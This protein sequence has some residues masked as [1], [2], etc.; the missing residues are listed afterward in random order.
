[1]KPQK[2]AYFTVGHEELSKQARD[3]SKG[4]S[5]R[6]L[7]RVIEQL[8]Y[9]IKDL[10]IAQGLG[11]EIPPD[12]S[13]V[14]VAGPQ[15]DLLPAE[16]SS[17]RRYLERGGRMMVFLDPEAGLTLET[18][19]NP[20]G[21]KFTPEK[22]ANDQAHVRITHTDADR[23]N[24]FSN[25]FSAHPSVTTLSRNSNRVVTVVPG[26]GYLE[27]IPAAPELG[28]KPQV[29]FTIHSMPFTWNDVNKNRI[30]DASEEKRKIYELAAVVTMKVSAA[31]KPATA[32]KKKTGKQDRKNADEMQMIVVAD[33]DLISDRVFRNPG[34]GYLFL[35]GIK[36]LVGEEEI[37]G[38]TTSEEDVRIMHTRKEDQIWFYL[39]IFG[40]PAMVLGAGLFYTRSIR[41]R[42][43]A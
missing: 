41:R 24:L 31:N 18:L 38:E 34:N 15:K 6:D 33:S 27:E 25:R 43:K 5:I 1:M 30:F 22:L 14:I 35:D 8:N 20:F 9:R 21:L 2:V 28:S 42:K 11:S 4:S 26:A 10:G 32:S 12:A 17:L 19:L 3:G 36:W 16:I 7:R 13:V 23:Y 37:I 39:T 40:V 29:Q